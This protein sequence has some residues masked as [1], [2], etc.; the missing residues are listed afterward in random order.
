MYE[1]HYCAA[2]VL[3]IDLLANTSMVLIHEKENFFLEKYTYNFSNMITCLW[4]K[5]LFYNNN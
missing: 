3:I 5:Y 2:L 4:N 1:R